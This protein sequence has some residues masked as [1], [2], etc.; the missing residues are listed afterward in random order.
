MYPAK[1]RAAKLLAAGETVG[2]VAKEVGREPNTVLTW[3]LDND[4]R[5]VVLDNI[6]AAAV[7]LIV[8]YLAMDVVPDKERAMFALALLRYKKTPKSARP[9]NG[10]GKRDAEDETDL[11]E[12]SEEQLKRLTGGD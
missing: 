5:K 9:P 2:D 8:G 11:E 6:E 3:M 7:R 4:F 1:E 12:F 10:R